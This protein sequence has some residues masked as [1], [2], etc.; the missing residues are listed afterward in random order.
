MKSQTDQELL[1][2][3]SETGS[4]AAFSEVVQRHVD[5]VF[6]AALRMVRDPHLAEDVSQRV[7]LALADNARTLAD[8]P[9]LSGWLHRTAQNQAANAIR[10][11]VRRRTRE[12]EAS[13]MNEPSSSPGS[14]AVWDS[15]APQLDAVLS[16][17]NESDRDALLLRYFERKSARQMA[18][19]LGISV[20]AAQKR[21]NRAVER[22]R[23]LFS[24]RGITIGAGGMI[25]ILDANA[26]QAAPVGLAG[27][28]A[29]SA[30]A[31]ASAPLSVAVA[32]AQFIAMTTLQKT[33]I[34]A[35][36][37]AVLGNGIYQAR[38][39]AQ[40]REQVHAL[41]QAS[42]EPRLEGSS[43]R[44]RSSTTA[45]A[46]RVGSGRPLLP[47][48]GTGASA[49]TRKTAA[50]PFPATQVYA[51]LTN[52]VTK[53]TLAQVE[54]YLNAHQRSAPSLL[55]AY[56]TT[57]DPALLAEAV[58]K[59]PQDPRVNFEAAIRLEA[60]PE[61]R[62]RAL[63][64]F[65]QAA[66]DNS[67]A[68]YLSAL[69]HLKAGQAA[70]GIDD[71]LAAS[72]KAQFQCYSQDRILANEEA[73]LAAGYPP[74]EA[75]L[76]AN[77][78]LVEPYLVQMRELGKQL[79]DLAGSYQQAG[80]TGSQGGALQLA[81]ELGRRFGEP[82]GGETLT[83]QLVGISIE[84]AALAAMD[85]SSPIEGTGGTVQERLDQLV[86]Q[87]EAYHVLANDADPLWATLSD[88]DWLAY[89]SQFSS[90]GEEA[91]LQW[92]V[93]NYGHK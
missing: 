67:M 71:L 81:A 74:A 7:F 13:A 30:L 43:V 56:R 76:I 12:E 49:T 41:Q 10:S 78:F 64:E 22:L 2:C 6:S 26:V 42:P 70:A 38:Q 80:D 79:T 24:R 20:D 39:T 57:S 82:S 35:T 44:P 54:P 66:P 93:S 27:S 5:L 33:L 46:R 60:A 88:Q 83:H 87:K 62:R 14:E 34:A 36:I 89:Y 85:P 52:K 73:Y 32:T 68:S 92:L 47:S 23:E 53:L 17:L 84:R 86:R 77:M 72:G 28:I 3:Y 61:E 59:Y 21:V 31:G 1:L 65:K 16:E 29:A 51:L 50:V 69:D 90:A 91:A 19:S 58:Q 40:L 15:V 25:L 4:E 55:A 45:V 63:D 11:D 75:K 18:Q 8:R 9:M 37:A 48:P